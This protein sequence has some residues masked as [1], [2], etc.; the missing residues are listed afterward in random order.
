MQAKRGYQ[1][2][3]TPP[4]VSKRLWEQS[5]H[6]DLYREHMFL[7]EAEEQTFGLKPMNCPESTFIYRSRVRSYR[8][9][10]LRLCRVRRAPS[11][12]AVRRA[13]RG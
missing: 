4:L 5:G 12:R 3:Y 8:E 13:D 9:L 7:V 2:I 10:P 6:W 1:E 11:Q